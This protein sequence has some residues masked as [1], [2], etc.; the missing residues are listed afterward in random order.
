MS[1]KPVTIDIIVDGKPYGLKSWH[2]VPRK[3]DRIILANK[4][5]AKVGQVY[6]ADAGRESIA[7]DCWVQLVCTIIGDVP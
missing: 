2:H 1:D 3:G 5:V 7:Y 4:K 6:W